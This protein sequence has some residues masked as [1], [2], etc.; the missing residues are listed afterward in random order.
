M[1]TLVGQAGTV[2]QLKHMTL[3]VEP[4]MTLSKYR[5]PFEAI[6]QFRIKLKTNLSFRQIGTLFKI[7]TS[8]ESIRRLVEDT[9]YAVT[10]YLNDVLVCS[11]LGLDHLTRI[12]ALTHHV[13]YRKAAFGN[14]LSII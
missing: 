5:T 13:A 14:Q 11:D 2:E 6:C 1:I 4:H 9:F 7:S 3:I 8:E 10:N 12:E